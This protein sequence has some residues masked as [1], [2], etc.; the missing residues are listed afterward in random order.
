MITDLNYLR[1]MSEG[2]D[3]FIN[4][5]IG[6]FKD[7]ILEYAEEMPRLLKDADYGKLSKLA[8]KAKSSV[9]IMGMAEE[10]DSLMEL[11][12]LARNGKDS[13]T[14]KTYIDRFIANCKIAVSELDKDR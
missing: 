10:A 2:D 13:D 8:H 12:T 7:Q 3:N 9:A 5:M 6:I 1:T 14:Y 11:E 4:E